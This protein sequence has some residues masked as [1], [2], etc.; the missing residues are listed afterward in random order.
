[1]NRN[2]YPN[3]FDSALQYLEVSVG[4]P[5]PCE[6]VFLRASLVLGSAGA[7]GPVSGAVL[8]APLGLPEQAGLRACCL[9]AMALG[10]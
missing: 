4:L 9:P 7:L 1:M 6:C 2:K 5:A 3:L 10:A 8:T